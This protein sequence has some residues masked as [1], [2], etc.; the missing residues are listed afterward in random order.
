MLLWCNERMEAERSLLAVRVHKNGKKV[1]RLRDN[2]T[3]MGGCGRGC[4]FGEVNIWKHQLLQLLKSFQSRL[5]TSS[6]HI[7]STK[8]FRLS[9]SKYV[10]PREKYWLLV[11][12]FVGHFGTERAT[13]NRLFPVECEGLP[14][15]GV[16]GAT[17][18][19]STP[20]LPV[21][22]SLYHI[23]PHFSVPIVEI[24]SDCSTLVHTVVVSAP[25]V[26]KV[27]HRRGVDHTRS[28][29]HI[30]HLQI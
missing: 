14:H 27:E 17:Q 4:T 28:L 26:G 19:Y 16:E 3:L 7:W 24:V 12:Y 13:T 8:A 22:H 5:T 25:T 20:L 29:C 10:Q 11:W 21:P 15:S 9:T 30:S 2:I 6:K 23:L 1:T 18:R